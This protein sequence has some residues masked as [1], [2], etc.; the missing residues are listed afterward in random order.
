MTLDEVLATEVVY[1]EDVDKAEIIPVLVDR[2][3]HDRIVLV[4]AHLMGGPSLT[5]YPLI[6]EYN[7]RWRCWTARPTDKQREATS[8]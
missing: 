6:S 1:A 7:K 3:A 2:R 8:W 4:R 5:T